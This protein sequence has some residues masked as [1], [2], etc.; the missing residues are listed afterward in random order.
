MDR[1][2]SAQQT[3]F[4]RERPPRTILISY[5]A[6]YVLLAILLLIFFLL[7][8]AE[9]FHQPFSL[10]NYTLQYPFAVHERVTTGMLYSFSI[11]IPGIIIVVYTLAIDGLFSRGSPGGSLGSEGYL[12]NGSYSLG[13]RIWELHSGIL[14][15]ALSWAVSVVITQSLKVATGKPRPDLISRCLPRA[16]SA[17]PPVFGLSN[18]SICTQT[19][20]D[21]L[22]DGFRSFPSGHSSTAFAGLFYLSL[23]LGARI[24]VLDR[25]GQVWKVLIFLLP[26]L[27]AALIADSR[28]MDARHHGFDVLSGSALGIV[29]AWAGYRQ[30]FPPI[31]E[32]WRKGR[33]YPI[34]T[35]GLPDSD[36]PAGKEDHSVDNS[37]AY[38]RN[39]ASA[40]GE[41]LD[42]PST[43]N[44]PQPTIYQRNRTSSP[45]VEPSLVEAQYPA[46]NNY[47]LL[48]HQYQH[49]QVAPRTQESTAYDPR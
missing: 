45:S 5:I 8:D 39:G 4:A 40:G 48:Q 12:R 30:Y 32:P 49:G 22:K 43:S 6:D 18:T 33:A 13:A 27:G 34:R 24:H 19:D 31:T 23:F 9:P 14:G 7:D 11:L 29:S 10:N 41:P 2:R 25:R 37:A 38:H 21:I 36:D 20:N 47:E 17:D 15:L 28:I 44:Q 42:A 35:W 26:I 46:G 1:F 3:L 16:G